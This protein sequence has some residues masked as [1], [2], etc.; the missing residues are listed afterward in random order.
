VSQRPAAS[1]VRVGYQYA[2]VKFSLM[3]YTDVVKLPYCFCQTALHDTQE[4]SN[5]RSGRRNFRRHV[6]KSVV[7][8]QHSAV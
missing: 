8:I 4:G 5:L 7:T 2:I 3:F 1:V 6:T